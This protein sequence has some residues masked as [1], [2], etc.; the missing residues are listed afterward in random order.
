MSGA[1]P[2]AKGAQDVT[3]A[4]AARLKRRLRSCGFRAT[5]TLQVVPRDSELVA[6]L[7]ITPVRA[8]RA[9]ALRFVAQK[10]GLGMASVCVAAPVPATAGAGSELTVGSYTGDDLFGGSQKVRGERNALRP[11]APWINRPCCPQVLAVTM[12]PKDDL[13]FMPEGVLV[14]GL[15][16]GM[17]P[18]MAYGER[19]KV[20]ADL[21]EFGS[22]LAA[23][24]KS[25]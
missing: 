9:F 14:D 7:H 25:T 19:V 15:G 3:S 8:S 16:V 17:Q 2:R 4:M 11:A 5:Y 10:L 20:A 23:S 13:S 22:L 1:G 21:D 18:W 24:L 12:P 6:V